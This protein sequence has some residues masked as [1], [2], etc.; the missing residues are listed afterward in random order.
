MATFLA[1]GTNV[2]I[3]T[4]GTYAPG[5]FYHVTGVVD[6]VKK[7]TRIYVDGQLAGTRFWSSGAPP[8]N[9][10]SNLWTMGI[11]APGASTY[12]DA[13]NA[14]VDEVRMLPYLAYVALSDDEVTV[15]GTG[16]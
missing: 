3:E 2:R 4:T 1:D 12:R 6:R 16:Y 9:L 11:G 10:G 13:A 15:L 14:I 7:Q 5:R 8:M